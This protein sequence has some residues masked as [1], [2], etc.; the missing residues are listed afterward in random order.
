MNVLS[1]EK[2]TEAI[3]HTRDAVVHDT[4]RR[5][6][7]QVIERVSHTLYDPD[8]IFNLN[9]AMPP[10]T[11]EEMRK[12]LLRIGEPEAPA[13]VP[14]LQFMALNQVSNASLY[15]ADRHRVPNIEWLGV[16]P[17]CAEQLGKCVYEG[18]ETR[19]L[20][21]LKRR[22]AIEK[23]A[24]RQGKLNSPNESSIVLTGDHNVCISPYL[25]YGCL[26]VRKFYWDIK[27]AYM[28]VGRRSEDNL[29]EEDCSVNRVFLSP[30]LCRRQARALPDRVALLAR[31]LLSAL[32]QEPEVRP[33]DRQPDGLSDPMGRHARAGR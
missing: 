30:A 13:P 22:L 1:F 23:E 10:N 15:D 27:R 28:K 14:D 17:E 32:V 4:C 26:S 3:W 5:Q 31:V 29:S 20:E 16:W 24:F 6:N 19:A 18:G 9:N 25:R 33:S 21:Q 8:E 11:C 7:V 2:D 12:A